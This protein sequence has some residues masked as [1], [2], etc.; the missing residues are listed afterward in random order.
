MSEFKLEGMY[1]PCAKCRAP[2][3]YPPADAPI[4]LIKEGPREG[5][6]ETFLT[7]HTPDCRALPI[8]PDPGMVVRINGS[9]MTHLGL[10]A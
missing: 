9:H 2:L 3:I 6:C 10:L 7:P 5:P 4:D 1:R 8:A